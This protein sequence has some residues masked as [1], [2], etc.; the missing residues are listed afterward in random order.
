MSKINDD[1]NAPMGNGTSRGWNGWPAGPTSRERLTQQGY[2]TRR[3]LTGERGCVLVGW[4][5]MRK[6]LPG[7]LSPALAW[8]RRGH[9]KIGNA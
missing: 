6:D 7:P 4:P 5:G 3:L 2:P 1:T 8:S 9:F